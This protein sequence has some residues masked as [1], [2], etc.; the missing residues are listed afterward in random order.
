MFHLNLL[1]FKKNTKKNLKNYPK[2]NMTKNSG[3]S[4]I[5]LINTEK[6]SGMFTTEDN[7]DRGKMKTK[8]LLTK[9]KI[10]KWMF[11]VQSEEISW[12][13]Q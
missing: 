9:L 1:H 13:N 4:T 2:E 3:M 5:I 12:W 8:T 7:Q 6:M 10:H 11:F